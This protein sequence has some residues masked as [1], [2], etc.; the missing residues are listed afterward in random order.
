MKTVHLKMYNKF[1]L[2]FSVLIVH[3]LMFKFQ[4]TNS[5]IRDIIGRFFEGIE[6]GREGEGQK[7][8]SRSQFLFILI[9]VDE[10]LYPG[11]YIDQSFT[12]ERSAGNHVHFRSKMMFCFN[13]VSTNM[14]ICHSV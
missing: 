7:K 2:C 12:R 4:I 1:Q 3:A 10:H 11:L 14:S 5:V 6:A 9:N 13:T 8:N